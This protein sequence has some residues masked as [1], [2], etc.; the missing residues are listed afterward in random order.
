VSRTDAAFAGTLVVPSVAV[1]HVLVDVT[2]EGSAA[3]DVVPGRGLVDMRERARPEGGDLEAGPVD[4]GWDPR[5]E[6]GVLERRQ[7]EDVWIAPARRGQRPRARSRQP[8]PSVGPL[9]LVVIDCWRARESWGQLGDRG[10]G[11]A[12]IEPAARPGRS[13]TR[14][15]AGDPMAAALGLLRTP[16]GPRQGCDTWTRGSGPDQR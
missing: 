15:A 4:G 12:G 14:A 11:I 7:P 16:C 8:S 10:G 5:F 2:N 9:P 13:G 6:G 3:A 1:A